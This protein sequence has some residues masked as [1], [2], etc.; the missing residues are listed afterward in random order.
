MY[1]PDILDLQP[2]YEAHAVFLKDIQ[3]QDQIFNM[4]RADKKETN[5]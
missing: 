3:P 1:G 4:G 5:T 2:S